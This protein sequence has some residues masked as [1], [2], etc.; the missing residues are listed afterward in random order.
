MSLSISGCQLA[1]VAN[2][3]LSPS[4]AHLLGWHSNRLKQL[5]QRLLDHSGSTLQRQ[6]GHNRRHDHVRPSG[7]GAEYAKGSKQHGEIAQHI[8]AGTN[9]SRTHVGVTT[10]I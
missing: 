9:P 6:C 3:G 8:V 4:S 7:A 1:V 2:T 5:L 10:A